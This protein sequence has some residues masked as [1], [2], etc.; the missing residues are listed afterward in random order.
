MIR[1]RQHPSQQCTLHT[2]KLKRVVLSKC[3]IFNDKSIKKKILYCNKGEKRK[4][5]IVQMSHP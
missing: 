3:D 4:M 5:L 1:D 2:K